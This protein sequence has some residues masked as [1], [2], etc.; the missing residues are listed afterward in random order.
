MKKEIV[1]VHFKRKKKVGSENK[2]LSRTQRRCHI[3]DATNFETIRPLFGTRTETFAF[4]KATP[5]K[6]S[7]SLIY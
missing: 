3:V 7:N 5:D 6:E 4:G 1:S 2:E